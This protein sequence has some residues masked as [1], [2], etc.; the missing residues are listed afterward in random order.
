MT[1]VLYS[2]WALTVPYSIN[3]RVGTGFIFVYVLTCNES[4]VAFW[5]LVRGVRGMEFWGS[6]EGVIRGKWELVK[7]VWG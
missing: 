7:G 1:R 6:L 4:R 5:D 2:T 3:T